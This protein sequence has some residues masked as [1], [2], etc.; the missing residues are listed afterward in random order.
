MIN[1]ALRT[2]ITDRLRFARSDEDR[3]RILT[4][5]GALCELNL[6]SLQEIPL[7]QDDM[8]R[9][10]KAAEMI[11]AKTGPHFQSRQSRGE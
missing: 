7:E 1:S 9:L 2:Q 6:F 4:G 8:K 5:R 3:L 11:G 10:R